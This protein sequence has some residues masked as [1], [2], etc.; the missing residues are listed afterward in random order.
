MKTY[1]DFLVSSAPAMEAVR[2]ELAAK[3][4]A[5]GRKNAGRPYD[6]TNVAIMTIELANLYTDRVLRLYHSW[7]SEQAAD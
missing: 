4:L 6:P 3:V 5:R 1:D 7:L 2:E